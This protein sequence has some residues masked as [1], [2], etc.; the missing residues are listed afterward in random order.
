[1]WSEEYGK[2]QGDTCKGN[3]RSSL[4]SQFIERNRKQEFQTQERGNTG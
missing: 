3:R 1:M 4:Y 2:Q